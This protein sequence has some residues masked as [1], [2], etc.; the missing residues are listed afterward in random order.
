MSILTISIQ[1]CSGKLSQCKE[2]RKKEIKGIQ[3]GNRWHNHLY[4]IDYHLKKMA[5]KLISMFKPGKLVR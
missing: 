2:A 1:H 5:L 4:Y 3:V